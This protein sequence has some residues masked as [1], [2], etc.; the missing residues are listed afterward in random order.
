M[1]EKWPRVCFGDFLRPHLRPYQLGPEQDANLVGM[2][3][4]GGGAFHRELK[5]AMRIVKKSHFI[6]RAGDV[7]YNK[8]FAWKGTFGVVPAEL[9]SMFVSDKFPTY[10]VDHS[11]MDLSYLRWYFRY[12]PLWDE[13]RTMSTGSAA[14]SKLTLNPPKFLLLT[15]PLPPLE[16]QRRVVAR[17]EELTADIDEARALRHQATE[18]AR[19]LFGSSVSR[20]CFASGWPLAKLG[21]IVPKDSLRNGKS[22]KSADA[23]E[24]IRCLTLS[25]VRRGRIQPCDSKPVPLGAVEAKPFLVRKGDVFIVRGSGRRGLCG[26]AGVNLEECDNIIFPDLFIRVPLPRERISAKFFVAVWNSPATR[27]AIEERAQT[28]SGIWKINQ[29]HIVSTRIPVPPLPEQGR[30]VADLDA[31]QRDL[32]AV[33]YLQ[34]ETTAELDA[35]LPAILYR[36]FKGELV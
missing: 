22:V 6:I 24:G 36:A 9:D 2:R 27:I 32:D 19:A 13:A 4:Y 14:L 33:N 21:D 28:T 30:I 18:E 3:L 8:L 25:S 1:T 20:V 23:G 31:V 34:A 35:L 12:P 5:P 15:I 16:E 26:R 7:V 17:I 29:G 10:E 11:K